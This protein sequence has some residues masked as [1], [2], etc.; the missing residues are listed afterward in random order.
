MY[1]KN[2]EGKTVS[3]SLLSAFRTDATN[4][5][6]NAMEFE[7]GRQLHTWQ[8]H[9]VKKNH[10]MTVFAIEMHVLVVIDILVVA[11]A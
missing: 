7:V 3:A 9:I 6:V 8:W 2:I 11:V 4:N 1:D 10:G 5:E